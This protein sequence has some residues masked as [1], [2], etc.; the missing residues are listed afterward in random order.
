MD[1]IKL[2]ESPNGHFY[3]TPIGILPS[4]T[5]IMR[6]IPNPNLEAWKSRTPDWREISARAA[7][8]GT[9]THRIIECY[10]KDE[11]LDPLYCTEIEKPF[12]AFQDWHCSR[13][14]ELIDSERMIW[15][16]KRYAGTVDLIGYLNGELHLIDLKTS[17][18]VYPDYLLQLAAYRTG[19][20]ERTGDNI[21][22]MGIL[23]LDKATGKFEWKEYCEAEYQAALDEFLLLCESWHRSN[24]GVRV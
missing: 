5:T 14:F 16:A 18:A 8:I 15:S 1:E 9:K 3:H 21:D 24:G 17:K 6:A 19:Y 11:P 10:L 22:S 12:S 20:E 13:G 23:R 4:V 7:E 2:I